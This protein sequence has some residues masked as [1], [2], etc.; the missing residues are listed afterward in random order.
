MLKVIKIYFN[1]GVCGG[2]ISVYEVNSII[3]KYKI[4]LNFLV[5]CVLVYMV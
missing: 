1:S 5:L 3:I 2:I 4:R